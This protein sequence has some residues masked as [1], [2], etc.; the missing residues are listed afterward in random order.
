MAVQWTPEQ[1]QVITLRD[2]N[3]LVSAAAGSGKTAVLVERII[4][5]IM[6]EE[7][8][9]NI[10]Q[11][12]I[13]TFTRKAAGEM[14]ERIQAAIEKQA[15]LYPNNAHL[16]RQRTRI[17]MANIS[18]IHSF[19]TDI[20]RNHFQEIDLDPAFRLGDD[21]ELKLMRK[22]V[23]AQVLEEY[24]QE[25][26]EQFH[27][28][29]ETFAL[30]KSDDMLED[31]ILE[32]YNFAMSFPYPE[33]WLCQCLQDYEVD[34]YEDLMETSWMQFL[35]RYLEKAMEH[36][37]GLTSQLSDLIRNNADAQNYMD[38]AENYS[39]IVHKLQGEMDYNIW[40]DYLSGL[41]HPKLPAGKKACQDVALR[42]EIK[43]L[44]E[45]MKQYFVK[46]QEEYFAQTSKEILADI[47]NCRPSMQ[48]LVEVTLRFLEAFREEKRQ[49]NLLDFNDLEH[50]TL[51]ILLDEE[52]NPTETARE[53]A[54]YYEEILIDEYQDSN[55]IQESLLNA[56]SKHSLGGNNLFMVGDA[57]QSIYRFR[58]ARPEL[59]MEK[60]NSY[61]TLEGADRRI[62]LH[63]NFRS[64]GEVLDSAN[65]IFGKIMKASL[66]GI[67]YDRDAALYQGME[68]PAP[69][70][71]Q[72]YTTELLLFDKKDLDVDD[73]EFEAKLLAHRI[74]KLVSDTEGLFIV[75]KKTKQYRRARYSDIA[76]LLRSTAGFDKILTEE[77]AAE[78]IPA[79]TLSREGYFSALEIVTVLNYLR[80]IDNPLQDI[81]LL[82]VLKSPMAAFTD[83]E[84]AKLRIFHGEDCLYSCLEAYAA[85]GEEDALREKVCEF[86]EQLEQFRQRMYYMPVHAFICHILDVTGY[87]EYITVM[88][89]G[90]QRKANMDMLIE[91]ASAFEQTSY[92]GV[93]QFIRYMEQLQKYEV[94]MGEASTL[95]EQDNTVRIMTI[96][97]SKGLEF[98][99]VLVA[100]LGKRFN[101]RDEAKPL[102]MDAYTGI[103]ADSIYL[104]ERVKSKTLL[105]KSIVL[106][107]RLE[108]MGEE[109]RVLYV[110]LTRA[111]EKLILSGGVANLEGSIQGACKKGY[112][113]SPGY[114]DLTEA[115][116]YLDWILPAL[117]SH[118]SM[119][120]LVSTFVEEPVKEDSFTYQTLAHQEPCWQASFQV[121]Q[122]TLQDIMEEDLME[123]AEEERLGMELDIEKN[124]HTGQLPEAVK[125]ALEYVY[126]YEDKAI[127][128]KVSVSEIKHAGMFGEEEVP[129]LIEDKEHQPVYPSFIRAR[130]EKLSGS[131]RG[132]AYHKVLAGLDLRLADTLEQVEE[133][134]ENMYSTGLL[135]ENLRDV[136]SPHKLH[137]FAVSPIGRRMKKAVEKRR[138]YREQPFVFALPACR[139]NGDTDSEELVM[140]QGIIDVYFEEDDKLVLLDYKTDYIESRQE[141][142]L[143]DRY[144]AQMDYYKMALEAITGKCVKESVLY[145]VCLDKEIL[146]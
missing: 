80:I 94:D 124:Q 123:M 39:N 44:R 72:D 120:E 32:L 129:Q 18:T 28:F 79:H 25:G 138:L 27:H 19:C 88:P 97:A 106:Q 57:K 15:V 105:K 139:L 110:A 122:V 143:I 87:G 116:G 68:F 118:E 40:Y 33:K 91:R 101:R 67:E 71:E 111:K 7:H 98:P 59:F 56:V 61:S 134:L 107:N 10:D 50:E 11:F 82:S 95:S 3:I 115:G 85:E 92:T 70:H 146:L 36:M 112:K 63:K 108:T 133:Q 114:L 89:G 6:D 51:R 140:I 83:D 4:N 65:Y 2:S 96:H 102:A 64:R 48:M 128:V 53:Y 127:P 130:E 75:D 125:A 119:E 77:L 46:L 99:I 81:P 74:K 93:F 62:D 35:F 131:D 76:I 37:A 1:Q 24:Y 17:H 84:L 12:V 34:T 16:Q 23:L 52:G 78:G 136:I 66:G 58:L 14:R 21:G 54:R 5:K 142:R 86:I 104:K 126:P 145:S 38:I 42:E 26:R 100:G 113:Q 109:L 103:G 13:V 22:D 20:I 117:V 31:I 55:L 45:T 137:R 60:F 9:V 132:T 30:G 73:K 43:G 29:S 41:A 141:S 144:K 49:R 8:P 90:S 121:K 135:A 47:K 69:V